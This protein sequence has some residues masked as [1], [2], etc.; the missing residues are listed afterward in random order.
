MFTFGGEGFSDIIGGE[1]GVGIR[2]SLSQQQRLT[3]GWPI[4]LAMRNLNKDLF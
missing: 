2:T 4:P 1:D 3:C